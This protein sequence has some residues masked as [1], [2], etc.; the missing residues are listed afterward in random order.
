MNKKG[1]QIVVLTMFCLMISTLASLAFKF[2]R[3]RYLTIRQT[4]QLQHQINE[5]HQQNGHGKRELK[6]KFDK[7]HFKRGV[8]KIFM[9][10][11][12]MKVWIETQIT[13]I[14]NW[15]IANC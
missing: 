6:L 3:E 14:D 13:A 7:D 1:F 5:F 2:I 4:I 15:S 8:H 9:D 12:L 11:C 10:F